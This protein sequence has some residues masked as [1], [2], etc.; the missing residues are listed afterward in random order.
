MKGGSRGGAE[1]D[2][3]G[4]GWCKKGDLL[5]FFF[6]NVCSKSLINTV[7]LMSQHCVKSFKNPKVTSYFLSK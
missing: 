6:Y 1:V 4:M 7:L 3:G 5:F 2:V